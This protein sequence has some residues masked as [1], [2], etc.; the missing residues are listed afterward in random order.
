MDRAN[1]DMSNGSQSPLV[2][3]PA[4]RGFASTIHGKFMAILVVNWS[5]R[6]PIIIIV[7][8]MISWIVNRRTGCNL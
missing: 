6:K 8:T 3:S 7:Y 1:K 4:T 5:P 2:I